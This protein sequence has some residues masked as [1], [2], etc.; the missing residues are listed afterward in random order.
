MDMVIGTIIG[1]V[2]GWLIGGAIVLR[3]AFRG[4]DVFRQPIGMSDIAVMIGGLVLW[5]MLLFP[6]DDQDDEGRDA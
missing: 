1:L 2:A 4:D 5:P 6:E 3:C